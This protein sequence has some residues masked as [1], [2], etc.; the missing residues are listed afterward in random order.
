MQIEV[1]HKKTDGNRVF[2]DKQPGLGIFNGKANETHEAT[3]EKI[4]EN[5][6]LHEIVEVY[7]GKTNQIELSH[8]S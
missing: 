7:C 6:S 4:K 5:G 3:I 8:E 1:S 2:H